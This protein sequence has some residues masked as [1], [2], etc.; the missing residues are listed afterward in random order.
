MCLKMR[1]MMAKVTRRTKNSCRSLLDHNLHCNPG[2]SI[3]LCGSDSGKQL[4]VFPGFAH[5]ET[6]ILC[7]GPIF[8]LADLFLG[9]D[10]GRV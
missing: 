2:I 7:H 1:T 6:C 4:L 9:R 8:D 3:P 10:M 5:M